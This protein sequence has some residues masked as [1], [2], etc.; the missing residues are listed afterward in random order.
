[1][2]K[3]CIAGIM[4]ASLFICSS[5][6]AENELK[7]NV[8]VDQDKRIVS[9]TMTVEGDVGG[10]AATGLVKNSNGDIVYA[11]QG[12]TDS[13]GKFGFSY[14]NNDENGN[15]TLAFCAPR[16]GL[17]VND[18]FKILTGSMKE[19]IRQTTRDSEGMKSVIENYGTYMNLDMTAFN[20]LSDK[21]AVYSFMST[22][23][24]IDLSDI[25]SVADGFYGAVI[26]R[27]LAENSD[28]TEYMNFLDSDIYKILNKDG[29]PKG[30]KESLFDELAPDLKNEVIKK[31]VTAQYKSTAELSDMLEFYVLEVS[32]EKAVQWTEVNPVMK[33]Y[34]EA[35]LLNVDFK[36]YNSLK[37]R[38]K[39]DNALVGKSFASYKE[40]ETAFNDAVKSAAAAEKKPSSN[41]GGGSSGGGGGGMVIPSV[42]TPAPVEKPQEPVT[43]LFTDMGDYMW[44]NEAVTYLADKGII[45]GMGDGKFAPANGLTR[46]EVSTIMVRTQK[47][48]VDGKKSEFNDI[49]ESRWSY[50]YVSAVYEAGLMI[51]VSD[52]MFGATSQITRNEFAVIMK[53]LIDLYDVKLTVNTGTK[54]YDDAQSIP[55][56][57]KE[58]VMYMKGT[59]LML[60]S[61]ANRFDGGEIITRAYA[62]DILYT[63]LNAVNYDA[64][65]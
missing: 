46:E 65:G 63:V 11:A 49:P 10:T 5:V 57:A 50:P 1:M 54:E 3:A 16:K 62:C 19:A 2:K 51:G 18:S 23:T 60:G 13:D 55:D 28:S 37:N 56:W 8:V 52:D 32:L 24:M 6:L 47:L 20:N 58:S 39:A 33:K 64:E 53:R 45:N 17:R 25:E 38:Q 21:D 59:G 7:C 61:I 41:G 48:S 12:F 42:K 26:I 31:A 34:K 43:A 29:V 14:L 44:A 30:K 27:T 15:Y 4:V 36:A 22:D 9:A 35:G 40:I